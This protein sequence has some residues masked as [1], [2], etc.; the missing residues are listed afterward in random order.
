MKNTI[1][2]I[3][4]TIAFTAAFLASGI[5]DVA[6]WVEIA[7]PF[8]AVFAIS[9]ALALTISNFNK[10]RRITYP[11]L[12]CISAWGYK[13]KLFKSKFTRNTYRLYK[14]KNRSYKNLFEYVQNLFD[15]MYA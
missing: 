14:W 3:L 10:I 13:H 4:Y 2:T 5:R 8:F 1:I 9:I 6:N 11:L 7:K 12:V 15:L